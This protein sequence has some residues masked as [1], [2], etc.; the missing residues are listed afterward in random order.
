MAMLVTALGVGLVIPLA[1]ALLTRLPLSIIGGLGLLYGAGWFIYG[2]A[3]TR[4]D[5]A[6]EWYWGVGV[7]VAVTMLL[8]WLVGTLVG[9][10]LRSV[11]RDRARPA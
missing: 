11:R 10:W 8:P 5:P 4:D 9:A 1:L 6:S 7:A 2:W 3:A